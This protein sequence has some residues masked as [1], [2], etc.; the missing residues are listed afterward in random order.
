MLGEGTSF[1]KFLKALA[2]GLVVYNPGPKVMAASTAK[3]KT[4]ARSQFRIGRKNLGELYV[5]IPRSQLF[6]RHESTTAE[7]CIAS[8]TSQ[9]ITSNWRAAYR[10]S[11]IEFLR[12]PRVLICVDSRSFD[13]AFLVSTRRRA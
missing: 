13:A 5:R 9:L 3:P 7:T 8:R 4:K 1:E 6:E 2:S 11:C 10:A 12:R